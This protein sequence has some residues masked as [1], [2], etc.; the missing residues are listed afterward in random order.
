[1][2]DIRRIADELRF[3]LRCFAGKKPVKILEANLGGPVNKR[4]GSGRL[5]WRCIVPLPP[6]S[7]AVPVVLK[8]LGDRGAALRDDA[9]VAIPIIRQFP[10]LTVADTVVIATREQ[11]GACGRTHRSRVKSVI[12]NRLPQLSCSA[13]GYGFRRRMCPFG[14][15][16]H[17]Q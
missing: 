12:R 8:H 11:G 7:G 4:A 10:D 16:R 6:G 2:F 9:R 5:I 14:Q 17:R 3:P 15:A 1:M 13:S